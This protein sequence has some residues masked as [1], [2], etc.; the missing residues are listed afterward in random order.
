MDALEKSNTKLTEE[1]SVIGNNLMF[2]PFGIGF[3]KV[4]E[5]LFLDAC[6]M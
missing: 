5:E 4:M 3:K 6:C 2:W 1:V